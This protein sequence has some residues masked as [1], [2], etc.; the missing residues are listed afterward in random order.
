M[1]SI[2]FAVFVILHGLVHLLYFGQSAGYFELQPGMAWPDGSWIFSKLLGDEP[3]RELASVLLIVAAV[4]FAAGGVGLL[5]KQSWWRP[6]VMGVAVYSSIIYLLL[7]DGAFQHLDNK[8]GIGI[9]I[10]LG[11][12]ATVFLWKSLP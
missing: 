7:W 8:G 3:T 10:N 9:L 5:L 12:L 4:G 2:V 1:L 11:I 6:V